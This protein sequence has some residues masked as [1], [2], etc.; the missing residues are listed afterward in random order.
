MNRDKTDKIRGDWEDSMIKEVISLLQKDETW[1]IPKKKVICKIRLIFETE[2][3]FILSLQI[4]NQ[5]SFP[6]S[7]KQM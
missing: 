3:R 7:A 5:S 4:I 6:L 2:I 1:D